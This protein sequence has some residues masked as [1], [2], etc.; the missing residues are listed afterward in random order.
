MYSGGQPILRGASVV[1]KEKA[2][3][4]ITKMPVVEL[5]LR[6]KLAWEDLMCG[7]ALATVMDFER[8]E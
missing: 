6:E 3:I 4:Q 8:I 2:P 5:E 7:S 1:N